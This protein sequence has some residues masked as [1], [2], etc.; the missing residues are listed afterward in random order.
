MSL[1]SPIDTLTI[2]VGLSCRGP[3]WP[4]M[5]D[6]ARDLIAEQLV[7]IPGGPGACSSEAN[8]YRRRV[9]D[10]CFSQ[11]TKTCRYNKSIIS[12][13][14]NRDIR[15]R[16][17]V[18]H[19]CTGCCKSYHHT[20]Y[21][22]QT[23]GI[24]ALY[25]ER[26][27]TYSRSNWTNA[28]KTFAAITGPSAILGLFECSFLRAHLK[29]STG[30]DEPLPA[31][32][33]DD[34]DEPAE[35]ITPPAGTLVRAGVVVPSRAEVGLLS[36]EADMEPSATNSVE[37]KPISIWCEN[38]EARIDLSTSWM[39]GGYYFSDMWICTTINKLW[40]AHITDQLRVSGAAWEARQH[41]KY[42]KTGKQIYQ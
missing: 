16:G 8:R 21:L 27:K 35:A 31:L 20:L 40:E 25:G 5:K 15:K 11:R 12:S 4:T 1:Q 30:G 10:A 36:L 2:R 29:Q 19:V 22:M 14:F 38:A 28:G 3:V 26:V 6:E 9:Y 24:K 23:L 42:L 37:V 34:D 18:E 39:L 7:V 32:V 17:V 13:L 41:T 33:G